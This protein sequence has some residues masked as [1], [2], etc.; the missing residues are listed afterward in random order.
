MGE[1]RQKSRRRGEILNEETRCIYCE[2]APDTIEHMPPTTFFENRHRLSGFE[3]ASCQACNNGT[4]A[5]DVVASF[6]LRLNPNGP[7]DLEAREGKALLGSAEDLAPGFCREITRLQRLRPHVWGRRPSG[8]LERRVEI[9]LDGPILR[10]HME[11]FSAKLG[12]ALYREYVKAPLPPEGGVFT[13]WLSGIP[14]N[15][16]DAHFRI[17]PNF[18]QLRQGKQVSG[19]QFRL[20]YNTDER[21]IVGAMVGFRSN[22]HISLFAVASPE[23]Y[24]PTFKA[25]PYDLMRLGQLRQRLLA[26]EDL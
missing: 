16:A 5:A 15:V 6:L 26:A 14:Q 3:F 22:L 18:D 1:A 7:S 11:V 20:R 24:A 25:M 8:V 17:L 2:A 23:L 19:D 10:R 4:K 21:T 12:M 13:H 9:A